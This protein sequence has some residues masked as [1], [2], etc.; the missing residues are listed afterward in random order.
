VD[1][2][3]DAGLLVGQTVSAL[4]KSAAIVMYTTSAVERYTAVSSCRTQPSTDNRATTE[5]YKSAR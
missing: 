4:Q 5:N 3:F 1:Q 2:R